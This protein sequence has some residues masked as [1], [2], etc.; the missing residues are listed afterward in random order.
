LGLNLIVV[1]VQ[2]KAKILFSVC[3]EARFVTKIFR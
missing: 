2:L 3:R 1:F